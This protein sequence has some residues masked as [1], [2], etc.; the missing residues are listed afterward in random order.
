V[1]TDR[2]QYLL[3]RLLRLEAENARLRGIAVAPLLPVVARKSLYVD[4]T[5]SAASATLQRRKQR[6]T[7]EDER[8]EMR[9]LARRGLSPYQIG[10]QMGM[11]DST[12]RRYISEVE[13]L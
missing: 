10:Y 11:S 12:V 4:F 7:T 13:A 8:A 5:T 2:E 3:E 6:R 1:T 9:E